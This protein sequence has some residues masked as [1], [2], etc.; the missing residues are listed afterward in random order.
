MAA[1]PCGLAALCGINVR[2]QTVSHSRRQVPH[3]LLTRPPLEYAR[4]HIPVRLACVRRAASVRPEPGSNS[5]LI[6]YHQAASVSF[7]SPVIS[8]QRSFPLASFVI[9]D[10][11]IICFLRNISLQYFTLENSR[12]SYAVQ[13]SRSCRSLFPRQLC[14]YIIMIFSC[15]QFFG[16][17]FQSCTV[18]GCS[19]KNLSHRVENIEFSAKFSTY[20][21]FQPPGAIIGTSIF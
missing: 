3:V 15:Q 12:V 1:W 11:R 9:A 7:R 8:H 17:N 16:S 14:N 6:V 19:V 2:F 5:L 10:F 20:L 21:H 18:S 4:R 13:F